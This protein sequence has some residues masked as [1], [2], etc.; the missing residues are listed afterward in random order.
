M[1]MLL[2][3]LKKC[4][5][6]FTTVRRSL[7]T[8]S[9][10]LDGKV[11]II[12]LN[13][14]TKLNA[15]TEPMG[16]ALAEVITKVHKDLPRAVIVTG[17]GRA[18]SAGGDMDWLMKR[19]NDSPANNVNVMLKFYKKFLI[20]RNLQVPVIAAM[21]GPAIGAGLALAVGGCDMRVASPKASMGFTFTRLGLHPGMAA[22]HFAP[23]LVGSAMAAD[24]L[25]S[26]RVFSA[27]E[28]KDM[29]L[30]NRIS[31]DA[32][33]ASLTMAEEICQAAPQ[34]VETTLMT[35]RKLQ[36]ANGLGLEVSDL[37]Y[38]H[39]NITGV[40][41]FLFQNAMESDAHYQAKTYNTEDLAEGVT[42]LKEKRSPEFT[43]H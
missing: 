11:G 14:P 34:A 40:T 13:N 19:H 5:T 20:L 27:Q 36:E 15:L 33:A 43:G 21:N 29:G 39:T 7:V 41:S 26:G 30:V 6:S 18:F 35:L 28:A 16:E 22:L 2:Q 12:T 24:I 42:A 38:R 9:T 1:K 8:Y 25:L 4:H 3:P 32:L 37:Y 10:G 17:A 23:Q 31:E